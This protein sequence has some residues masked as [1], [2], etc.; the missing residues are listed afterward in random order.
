MPIPNPFTL[1]AELSYRCPLRCPYCSNPVAIGSERYRDE[2]TTEE[3]IRVVGEAAALGVVQLGLSGGEP[4]LRRDLEEIVSAARS[5]GLY[6]TLVTAGTLLTEQRAETLRAA[7][8]DHVQVSIQDS[9]TEESDRLAGARSFAKKLEAARVSKA[10]GF[11]LTLNF[12]LHRQNLDRISEMLELAFTLEAD[13][14]ELANTQ[15]YGWAVLNEKSLVPTREQLHKAEG[16]VAAARERAGTSMTILYVLPDFYEEYPKPCMG[17]WGST[18]MVVAPNGETLPCQAASDIPDLFPPSVRD[19]PLSWIWFD[20]DA[21]NRFRGFEWMQEPCRT[22]PLNRQEV[23]FGGCR[24]QA[25]RLLGDPAATDP[26]CHLSPAHSAVLDRR[27]EAPDDDGSA[28]IGLPP[29]VYRS[30]RRQRTRS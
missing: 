27:S 29:L 12:V 15:Y 1:I 30:M 21:F 7:G 5:G 13:R 19:H 17:G 9:D 4:L 18:A 25:M 23:D 22:C 3:W 28:A 8:L 14:V 24:C 6:S 10:L 20:S 11:P 2:L 26:V 16:A